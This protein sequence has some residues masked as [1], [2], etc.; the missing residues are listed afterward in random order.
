MTWR[1]DKVYYSIA[2]PELTLGEGAN[3]ASIGEAI[4]FDREALYERLHGDGNAQLVLWA[5]PASHLFAACLSEGMDPD[6]AL[7]WV[8]NRATE[9]LDLFRRSRRQVLVLPADASWLPPE[10]IAKSIQ[11]YF[12]GRTQPVFRVGMA[13]MPPSDPAGLLYRLVSAKAIDV[14]PA[15]KRLDQELCAS[16]GQAVPDPD[17]MKR[18]ID[19]ALER[20]AGLSGPASSGRQQPAGIDEGPQTALDAQRVLVAE[21]QDA[22]L[23]CQEELEWYHR[24]SSRKGGGL[25][26]RR[27]E[28]ELQATLEERDVLRARLS[29]L[30]GQLEWAQRDAEQLRSALEQTRN[31]TSWK[32][33]APLR[34]LMGGSVS[35]KDRKLLEGPVSEKEGE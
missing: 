26:Q 4:P 2:H 30:E 15:L 1:G 9:I 5:A 28:R 11:A 35:E 31:S 8:Q 18:D 19:A 29:D 27:V 12:H 17:L 24:L 33:T 13:H 6:D 10:D 25:E 22:L 3:P 34:K 7:Q 20:L 14:S 16:M 32:L 23:V 21:I